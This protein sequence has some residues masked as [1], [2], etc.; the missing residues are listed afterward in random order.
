MRKFLV[1]AA[2][3]LLLTAC[4]S[5]QNGA[6][7]YG[8]GNAGWREDV[9]ITDLT[10]TALTKKLQKTG[11]DV[12][13]F[14]FNEANL[15]A[16]AKATLQTQAELLKENPAAL[17]VI[18]GRCD[19]RGTREYNLALGDKRANAARSYLIAKG[20]DGNRIRTISYGKDKPIVL[21]S[22]EE[23]WAKNRNATTVAY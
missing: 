5:T 17:V 14:S 18:E 19:E 1:V 3:A 9:D 4:S 2:S 12:V 15:D 13:Y 7:L 10:P 22:D 20:I 21:G 23:A 8:D 11:Q 16:E 6:E